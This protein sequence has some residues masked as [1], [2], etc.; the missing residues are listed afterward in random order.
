MDASAG[1]W[2]VP[3]ANSNCCEAKALRWTTMTPR[4][5]PILP[6]GVA[7]ERTCTVERTAVLLHAPL[8]RASFFLPI[9]KRLSAQV[10]GRARSVGLANSNRSCTLTVR[11]P[12]TDSLRWT[13]NRVFCTKPTLY[14]SSAKRRWYEYQGHSKRI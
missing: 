2:V 14:A 5:L 11:F 3:H 1:T 9:L 12:A 4:A 10:C 7:E 13:R 6:C 8:G